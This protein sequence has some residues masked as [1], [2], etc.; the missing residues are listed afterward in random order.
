MLVKVWQLQYPSVR[1]NCCIVSSLMVRM[2]L[3]K[4]RTRGKEA[5]TVSTIR[6]LVNFEFLGRVF[7]L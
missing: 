5:T 1:R 4:T 6:G 2:A 3:Q 7:K